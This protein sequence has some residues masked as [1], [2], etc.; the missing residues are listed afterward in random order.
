MSRMKAQ[1]AMEYL[2]IYGWAILIVIIVSAALF[3]LGIFDYKTYVQ[4]TS[5]GF[6]GFHVLKGAW[7][8]SSGGNVMLKVRNTHS[9]DITI[10]RVEAEH[11]GQTLI[12][13][14]SSGVISSG[15]EYIIVMTG[16]SDIQSGDPYKLLVS[17][18]FTDLETNIQDLQSSGTL[19]GITT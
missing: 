19:T 10:T 3:S 2:M 13:T 1:T 18:F 11:G 15:D 6:Y 7:E 16:F 14:T 4:Y 8:F 12:N 9:S 17:I 5:R